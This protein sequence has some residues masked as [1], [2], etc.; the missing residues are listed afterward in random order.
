MYHRRLLPSSPHRTQEE[1]RAQLV[2]VFAQM[3]AGVE[4]TAVRGLAA[5]TEPEDEAEDDETDVDQESDAGATASTKRQQSPRRS[6]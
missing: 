4:P 3:L 6:R 1:E 5:A 2:P